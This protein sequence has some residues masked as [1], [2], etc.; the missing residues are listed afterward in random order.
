[1][2][3]HNPKPITVNVSESTFMQDSLADPR[4]RADYSASL[5]RVSVSGLLRNAFSASG[6][7]QTQFGRGIGVTRARANQILSGDP[8]NFTLDLAGRAAGCL[9]FR[10]NLVLEDIE[11]GSVRYSIDLP[12]I[13]HPETTQRPVFS[14]LEGSRGKQEQSCATFAEVVGQTSDLAVIGPLQVPYITSDVREID[15]VTTVAS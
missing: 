4:F 15:Y 11:S 1:M 5:L 8:P 13:V 9:G 6:L 2:S 3:E 14:Y 12:T 10:W 7:S